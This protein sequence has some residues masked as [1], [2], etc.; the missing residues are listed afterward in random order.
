MSFLVF[1]NKLST[2]GQWI[3]GK[4]LLVSLEVTAFALIV[5]IILRVV[6]F[7]SA[8]VREAFWLI[9]LFKMVFSLFI[10]LPI[11]LSFISDQSVTSEQ[12]LEFSTPPVEQDIQPP[13]STASSPSMLSTESSKLPQADYLAD[14]M[15]W[16]QQLNWRQVIA[17][18]WLLGCGLMLGRLALGLRTLG[19]LR[20]NTHPAPESLQRTLCLCKEQLR[21]R[22]NVR[23]RLAD[24]I[25]APILF[26]FLRPVI[27]LPS[28]CVE[29]FSRSELRLMLTH[30]LAHWK[31][32]DTWVFFAKRLIEVSFFFHPVVWY[33]GKQVVKESET[34]CDELVVTLSQESKT[35]ANCLIQI[36]QR[37]ADMKKRALG[38]LAVGG[39]A[40]ANRIRKILE[41]GSRMFSTKIKPQTIIAL[42]LVA[43]LGLPS[44]F[45]AK[46]DSA[47]E[48]SQL[49]QDLLNEAWE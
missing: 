39:N 14:E 11:S 47:D 21:I 22:S 13:Q 16:W 26:G 30:E 12:I 6:R 18:L 29:R 7:R 1:L 15:A 9:V 45:V 25:A 2:V 19:K 48:E 33:A 31:Y 44:W 38:G 3:T 28:W 4:M 24:N 10:G 35:Y 49:P 17:V 23:L 40:T 37:A 20:N 41:E 36:L 34:A 27:I 8:R 32:R 46:G 43:L 5:W 42:A